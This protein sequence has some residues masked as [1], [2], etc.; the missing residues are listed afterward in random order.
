MAVPM[1]SATPMRSF[2]VTKYK[3]DDEDWEPTK[4]QVSKF[5]VFDFIF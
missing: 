5:L 3:F 2:S 4:Y 1:L